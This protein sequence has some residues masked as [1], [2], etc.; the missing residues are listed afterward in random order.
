MVTNPPA[1]PSSSPLPGSHRTAAPASTPAGPVDGQDRAVVTLVL[2]RR[3]TLPDGG[4]PLL[5]RAEL[6]AH[7]G[8]RPDDI[9]LVVGLL[10]AHGLEVL[11]TAEDTVVDRLVR[12]TGPV[13]VLAA[14]FGTSLELVASADPRSGSAVTHRQRTGELLLPAELADV[15][16][17]VLGLDDR[18]QARPQFRVAAAAAAQRSYTP[19][20]LGH[21]YRFPAGTDTPR[22]SSATPTAFRPAPTDPG[23]A[24]PSWN[25]VVALA[26]PI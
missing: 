12:V 11:S 24:W 16:T 26:R 21:A 20:Q 18:L 2:R 14:L 25:S 6:A 1:H 23:K 19:L 10:R 3:G 13:S 5:S 17:A 9:E 7:A 15:V 8:A 22:C 4:G